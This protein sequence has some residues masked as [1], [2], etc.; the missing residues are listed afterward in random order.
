MTVA[1]EVDTLVIGGGVVGMSLAYGLA[2]AGDRVCVLD[3]GDDA[4]RAARGN[5]GLVRCRAK[6]TAVR[7]MPAGH[8]T[9]RGTGRHLPLNSPKVPESM[10]SCRRS[11]A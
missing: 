5:F 9:R 11:A 8:W 3:Q 4:F 1:S 10:C 2:R 6:A 7:T